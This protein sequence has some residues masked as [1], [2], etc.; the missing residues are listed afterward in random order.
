MARD[1]RAAGLTRVNIS[2]DSMRRETFKEITGS[3]LLEAVLEGINCALKEGFDPVKINVV[4]L[5]GMNEA[6]IPAFGAV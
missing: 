3:D 4:L 5:E 2:L 1:L 6:D